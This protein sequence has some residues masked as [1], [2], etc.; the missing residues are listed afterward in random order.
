MTKIRKQTRAPKHRVH[1]THHPCVQHNLWTPRAWGTPYSPDPLHS[2]G[3][4]PSLFA[5]RS[6]SRVRVRH[7]IDS[8]SVTCT[9]CLADL[10]NH[11][12]EEWARRRANIE[13]QLEEHNPADWQVRN[14]R[15]DLEYWSRWHDDHELTVR[16]WL[17]CCRTRGA[18]WPYGDE[19]RIASERWYRAIRIR[20]QIGGFSLLVMVTPH[21]HE[22]VAQRLVA[23]I[24]ELDPA[25]RALVLPALEQAKR[26]D[27]L[28]WEAGRALAS[29]EEHANDVAARV[30]SRALVSIPEVN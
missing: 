2:K 27:E 9:W 29:I 8:E 19:E 25:D 24:E 30:R 11:T 13:K 18:P 28:L 5:C 1:F 20:Q 23:Q 10:A 21:P 3:R 14:Q 4:N 16:A 26:A 15:A 17:Q 22:S 7:V 6:R 12:E